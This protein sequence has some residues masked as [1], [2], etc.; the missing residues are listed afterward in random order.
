MEREPSM[1]R[2][3]ITCKQ[4]FGWEKLSLHLFWTIALGPAA[5]LW[6]CGALDA[7]WGLRTF[8][9]VADVA[10]LKD[11]DCPSISI[12]FAARDEA[13]KLPAALE[14]FLRLDYPR[15]EIVA[16]ND[17]S[18]D[19]TEQILKSAAQSNPRLKI[20]SVQ[21]LP[22]GWLG[23]P[24]AL[25]KAY[26][27]STGEWL[28][29]TD[30]D[31]QFASS[32]LRSAI[33]FA[34]KKGCDHLTLSGRI[35]M[36][37]LG[38]RIALTFFGLAFLM[39][40]RPWRVSDPKSRAFA[41][42][43]MFQLIRRSTYEGIGTHRRLAMEVVDDMKL[44]KLVKQNG[45]R[46]GV[47]KAHNELSV[48]WQSGMRNVIR[49]TT[50]NFFAFAGFSLWNMGTQIFGLLM[51]CVVPWIA[52]FFAH[53]WT[54]AFA[55]SCVGLAIILHTGACLELKVSPLYAL[56]FPIGALIF[57]WMQVRST[58]VTLWTGGITWRGTFYPL[59]ELKRGVV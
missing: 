58:I 40:V 28:I 2:D 5:L 49:G 26:E 6:I 24:H 39:G 54:L 33:A 52:L 30:A 11:P 34:K 47:A 9:S 51:M 21:E 59:K 41:G 42:V 13:E 29:F 36:F 3:S 20:V 12:L 57:I 25:Q 10:P 32:L 50:K 1:A 23:K 45:F 46:S 53:G 17:R 35:D 4:F 22:A 27:Q 55:C 15:Y 37:S 7:A 44:G 43:G 14:T 8:A 16:V 18:Q 19:D 48:H 38:E 31:V 56:T